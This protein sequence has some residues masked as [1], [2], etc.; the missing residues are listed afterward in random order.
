ML[1]VNT[2]PAPRIL[3]GIL[4]FVLWVATA[5]WG[6]YEMVLVRGM[7]F[8]IYGYV[9]RKD[10]W[11]NIIVGG[12]N[13]FGDFYAPSLGKEYWQAIALGNWALIPLSFIWIAVFI[14]GAEYHAKHLGQRSSW[15]LFG[16]IIAVEVLI[17]VMAL[18]I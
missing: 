9:I 3:S 5:A 13:C 4:T 2:A 8:R 17:L 14:G 12:R 18:L 7:L 15:K 16:W 10:F 1:K 6:L 11:L